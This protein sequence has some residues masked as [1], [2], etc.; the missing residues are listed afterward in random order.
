MAVTRLKRKAKKN[1]MKAKQRKFDLKKLLAKP[2]LKNVSMDELQK[3]SK[4]N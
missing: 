4:T 2:V 3:A 1:K